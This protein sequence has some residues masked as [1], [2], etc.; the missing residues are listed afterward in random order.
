MDGVVLTGKDW[1]RTLQSDLWPYPMD[2][3]RGVVSRWRLSLTR[4]PE[5]ALQTLRLSTEDLATILAH[6]C[7]EWAQIK[8]ICDKTERIWRDPAIPHPNTKQ[9]LS[10]LCKICVNCHYR[11][12]T[13]YLTSLLFELELKSSE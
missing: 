11:E 8:R 5:I 2:W 10:A 4:A 9:A 6:G 3:A 1:V 7:A 12:L 13:R